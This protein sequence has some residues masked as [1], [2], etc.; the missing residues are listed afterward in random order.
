[1]AEI[2]PP[3]V[4]QGGSHSAQNDRRTLETLT[5]GATGI[6]GDTSL[7]VTEKSGTPNM[8]VDVAA[9]RAVIDGTENLY[10]GVYHVD[11]Q[12]TVNLTVA[13]SD[14]SN[15][16]I[17]LVVAKVED[18]EYSGV[19]DAWSLAVVTGTPAA[20]PTAP[21]APAN[22]LVLAELSVAAAATS[23]TNADI[24]DKR[25]PARVGARYYNNAGTSIPTSTITYIPWSVQSYDP[26]GFST[27]GS[28]TLTVPT[29][30]GGLYVITAAVAYSATAG[31]DQ[32]VGLNTP[33][34]NAQFPLTVGNQGAGSITVPLDEGDT[35]RIW[36]YQNSGSTVSLSTS[37]KPQIFMFK[38]G[39]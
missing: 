4:L 31:T 20:S 38:I 18:S 13:A 16:R 15:P 25:V 37:S 1:M 9:G 39:W 19:T 33:L 10:Q 8:S 7:K 14:P 5:L 2:N 27:A 34:V 36:T 29:G 24:T 35:V 21:S 32:R 28:D 3:Y 23:I 12:A 30:H 6:I 22:S 17:D 11:N 26:Y